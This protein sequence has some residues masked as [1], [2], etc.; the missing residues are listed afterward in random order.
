MRLMNLMMT[1]KSVIVTNNEGDIG[2]ELSETGRLEI[3]DS[4]S[5]TDYGD[6]DSDSEGSVSV[7]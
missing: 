1:L 6:S 2:G 7:E 5:I 4:K 3:S